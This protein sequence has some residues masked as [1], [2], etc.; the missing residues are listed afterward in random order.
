MKSKYSLVGREFRGE[1]TTQSQCVLIKGEHI[2]LT[3]ALLQEG[4]KLFSY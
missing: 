1:N 2:Q 3:G 4:V